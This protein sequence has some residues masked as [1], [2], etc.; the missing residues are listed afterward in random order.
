MVNVLVYKLPKLKFQPWF[1][2]DSAKMTVRTGAKQEHQQTQ[3]ELH[4]P[5]KETKVKYL[6]KG[7]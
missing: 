4:S 6:V 3:P 7:P 2:W 5:G 1:A